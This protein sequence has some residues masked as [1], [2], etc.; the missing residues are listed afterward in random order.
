MLVSHSR[1]LNRTRM[2]R[3]LDNLDQ[4]HGQASTYYVTGDVSETTID[5]LVAALSSGYEQP[6]NLKEM[7]IGSKTDSAVFWG[8]RQKCLVR[9]PFPIGKTA[10]LEGYNT[11]E[12]RDLLERHLLIAVVLVRLGD[13]GIGVFD[14][15]KRLTSKTGTGLIHSRHKKGG[16]SQRRFERHRE[17][18]IEGFF[19][20]VCGHVREQLEPHAKDIDHLIYG[21]EENTLRSFRKQC[22]FL[23]VFDRRVM[24]MRLNVRK[25]RQHALEEAIVNVWSSELIEWVETG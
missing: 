16:S 22:G 24:Q 9:P 11:G 13:Y 21:G 19:T 3:F 4:I 25:P 12:L 17:K 1:K 20:R 18:Q 6:L 5:E 10:Q 7:I 23:S 8:E 2:L 15:E 14:Q